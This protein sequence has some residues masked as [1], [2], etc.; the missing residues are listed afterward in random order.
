M[1][2]IKKFLLFILLFI[3]LIS[4]SK[5]KVGITLLPYYSF[6]KNI[7]KDK[8]DV[9]PVLPVNAD[10]HSYQ[11]NSND[12]KK[13][14]DIDYVVVN[15][16]GHDEFIFPMINTAKKNNKKLQVIYANKELL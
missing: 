4:Y 3:P 10:V 6:V 14:L 8:M 12:I 7:V 15:G 1:K 5:I 9:V 13:L 2:K 11:A 16:I